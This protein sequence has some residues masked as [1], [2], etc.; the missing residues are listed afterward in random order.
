M[1]HITVLIADDIPAT[2]E[3]IKRLLYFEEDIKVIGEAEDGDEAM[4]LTE[5]LKP[6]V[7]LMDVNMPRLDG[8]RA[9]EMITMKNPEAAIVIVSIQGEKEYLRKAM[10]AGA[11]D[12]L[13]KPFSSGELAGTIRKVNEMN[14]KRRLHL[15]DKGSPAP[16]RARREPGKMIT[17]FSSKGGVGK[18]TTACNLAISLIQETKKKVALVDLNLQGGDVAVMLNITSRGGLAELVQENDYADPSL[19]ESYLSPH[20]SGVRVLLAPASPELAETVPAEKVEEIL[21]TLKGSY[22]FVVVDTAVTLN[23]V[24]LVCLEL[25]DHILTVL[26]QDLPALKHARNNLA[27]LEKLNLTYKTRLLL[28]REKTDALKIQEVEKNIGINISASLPEDDKTVGAS[29]NKGQPFV[30]TQPG[31]PITRAL[32]NLGATLA[33]TESS[34]SSGAAPPAEDMTRPARK[35]LIGKLFSF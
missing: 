18:T 21:K 27:I 29:V 34:V 35:S 9:S 30:L 25:S 32:L 2:R 14:K 3:D 28:N 17:L 15:V 23:D 12:Y 4:Q 19:L 13:V 5:N 7:V 33:Q 20:F 16:Y 22:D 24:T 11:R 6:D 10:A 8:I 26:T 31:A 1:N